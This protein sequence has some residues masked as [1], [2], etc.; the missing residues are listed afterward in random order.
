MGEF[1][2]SKGEARRLEAG[3]IQ[4]GRNWAARISLPFAIKPQSLGQL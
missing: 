3:K 1:R 2:G 4:V